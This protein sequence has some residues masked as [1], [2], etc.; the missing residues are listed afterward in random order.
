MLD[1]NDLHEYQ[2][3]AVNR[4][5]SQKK[6]AIWMGC[7]L[8]KTITVLTAVRW[9]LDKGK[10]KKVLV[11]APKN[12]VE[13]V[14]KQ[15]A[16]LWE[17]TNNLR[18]SLV[19]GDEKHRLAALKEEADIYCIS[20][21]LLYWLFQYEWFKADMLVL[22]EASGFKDRSTRRVASLL[23]KSITVGN[24]KLHRKEPMIKMFNRVCELTGTPASESYAGL[25][26]QIQILTYGDENPLGRTVTEFKQNYMVMQNFNGYPVFTHMKDGAIDRIN[27][28]LELYDLCISMRTEDYLE[29]PE[30]MD[31]VRY[32]NMEDKHYKIMEKEGI[33]TV[34]GTDIICNTPLDKM[35]KLQQISSGFLYDERGVAHTLNHKKEEVITELLEELNEPALVLYRYEYEKQALMKLGGIPLDNPKAIQDWQQGK[36]KVGLLYP[37]CAYGLNIQSNCS[38]I[39]WYT[40]SLS[41]E[42]TEQAIKRIYRQGQRN[43][44]R[45]FYIIFR[46]TIDEIV[47]NLIKN[48]QDVLNSLL[49]YFSV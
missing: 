28:I 30:K 31:I 13:N 29:L 5:C 11:V 35:N 37:S 44:V 1:I 23:Q 18:I 19:I 43:N 12:V 46:N 45:I 3:K 17:H 26:S 10:I 14:W 9:L 4:I 22:D 48:K 47:Y 41:G 2:K 49:K 39:I 27:H 8:G 40:Q 20:R 6:V 36:I 34:D 15:E 16:V 33:V 24:K 21:D 25:W 38:V 7:G 42:Q 32:L